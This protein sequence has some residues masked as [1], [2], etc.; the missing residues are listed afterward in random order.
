MQQGKGMADSTLRYAEDYRPGEAFDLGF[1]DMTREEILEFARRWDA[2]PFH[3]DEEAARRSHYGG[4]IASGWH[5]G[6][7]ML[8][9]MMRGFICAETTM[10]SP[11]QDELRFLKPVRP[12]DRLHGRVE[13]TGVHLSRSRPG[14]GFVSNTATLTNQKGECVLRMKSTAIFKTRSA[15][16]AL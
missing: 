3:V 7:V 14:M 16:Q 1:Y 8:K 13:V 9:L 4:I 5:T 15:A 12:G 6:L 2:Q 11:G 10:G